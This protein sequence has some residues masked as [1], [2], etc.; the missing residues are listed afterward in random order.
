MSSVIEPWEHEGSIWKTQ[1]AYFSWMRGQ[2]RR[3]LWSR[4]PI[5]NYIKRQAAIP[6]PAGHRAK[7]VIQCE[8]CQKYHAQ[9]KIEVDHIIPAGSLKE[10]A[11]VGPFM[12]R[13]LNPTGG[14]R[15]LCKPCHK[16]HTYAE[17]HNMSF[18]EATI[19]KQVMRIMKRPASAQ[20][21]YMKGQGIYNEEDGK[22]SY[23]RR[24]AIH[25]YLLN[26]ETTT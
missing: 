5:K 14:Y 22:N 7:K 3:S 20:I 25:N 24:I 9:S 23:K 13:M 8:F 16:T 6:A 17:K 15:L 4:N 11:D 18:A 1:A 12:E 2:I 19:A 21:Q 26:N 10:W